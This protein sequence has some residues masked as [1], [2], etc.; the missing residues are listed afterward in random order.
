[1]TYTVEMT[2]SAFEAIRIDCQAP[3]NA[4]RWIERM[5]DAVAS[6]ECSPGRG[7]TAAEAAFLAYAVRHLRVGEQLLLFTVNDDERRA[8]VVGS[9]LGPAGSG[10]GRYDGDSGGCGHGS[11]RAGEYQ[12]R[13][14][15]GV[16]ALRYR[17]R[18]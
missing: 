13:F 11:L 8:R 9:F 2:V 1:M 18:S 14:D 16:V 12:R 5:W 15:D 3:L 4:Q 10:A 17:I 6:L 7:A